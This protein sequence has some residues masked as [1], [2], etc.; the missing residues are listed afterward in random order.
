[1]G[2]FDGYSTAREKVGG[3][4]N[5][6]HPASSNYAFDVIMIELFVEIDGDPPGVLQKETRGMPTD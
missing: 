1:V 3:T 4:K 5:S 2:T 6:C